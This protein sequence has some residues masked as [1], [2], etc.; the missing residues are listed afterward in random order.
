MHSWNGMRMQC[1]RIVAVDLLYVRNDFMSYVTEHT[2]A[3]KIK[4][5]FLS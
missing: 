2:Y 4:S 3:I 1:G 5:T